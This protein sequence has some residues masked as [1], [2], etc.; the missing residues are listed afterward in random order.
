[1]GWIQCPRCFENLETR[2]T[3][4]CYICGAWPEFVER[5]G[6][7]KY[8]KYALPNG[9]E[10]ILC[11]GCLLEEFMAPGG[12]GQLL[13]LS[14]EENLSQ[15]LSYVEVVEVDRLTQDKFCPS[16]NFRLPFLKLI[17]EAGEE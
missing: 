2:E 13:N 17:V 10:I 1:M 9:Q 16:C 11:K 7:E 8:A 15:Y 12:L 4:P 6:K 3:T 5:L 14:E